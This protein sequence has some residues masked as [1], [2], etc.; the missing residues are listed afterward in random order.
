MK[1]CEYQGQGLMGFLLEILKI[2]Q[3]KEKKHQIF[4]GYVVVCLIIIFLECIPCRKVKGLDNFKLQNLSGP[5]RT[6][7]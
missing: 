3:G 4:N 1:G 5:N 6:L 7:L 2:M